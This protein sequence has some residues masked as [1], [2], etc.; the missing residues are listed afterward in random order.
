MVDAPR[1]NRYW[2]AR[3]R[4][5]RDR[6][7]REREGVCFVEGIRQVLAA[8]EGGWPLEAI[9]LDPGRLRSDVAWQTVD[10]ARSAGTGIVELKTNEFERISSRD[11]PA[12]IA[13]IVRWSPGSISDLSPLRNAVYLI[14]DQISDAGNLGT[15]VRT[16]DSLG[17]A[18]IIVHSGVD[19]AHPGVLR[20]SLGTA[21]RMPVASVTS[22]DHVFDWCQAHDIH[23]IAT[24]AKADQLVWDAN[25][26]GSVALLLGNE[27]R[28]LSQET[29]ERCDQTVRIPMSGTATSLNVGIAAGII[30]YEAQRQR[31]AG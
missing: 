31:S 27:G 3:V 25:L 16:A 11:N 6:S 2:I 8:R 29:I 1:S 20:A 18:G 10:E 5:L 9:L 14:T 15:L 12:G 13:A 19:P 21:F 22:L 4:E 24:S 17:V 30:L 7:V 28:G 26:T 23:T